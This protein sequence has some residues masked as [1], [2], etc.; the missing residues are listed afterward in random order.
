MVNSALPG[1]NIGSTYCFS[2]A[3]FSQL[4]SRMPITL[5]SYSSFSNDSASLPVAF[6]SCASVIGLRTFILR[7]TSAISSVTTQA[8]PQYSGSSAVTLWPIRSV[9]FCPSFKINSRGTSVFC[10]LFSAIFFSFLTRARPSLHCAAKPPIGR[11][12]RLFLHRSELPAPL[13]CAGGCIPG[14]CQGQNQNRA[15]HRSC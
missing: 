14:I 15:A 8:R 13:G 3:G 10:G 12:P 7:A 6:T 5:I 9:I 4:Y 2:C 1:T 11:S